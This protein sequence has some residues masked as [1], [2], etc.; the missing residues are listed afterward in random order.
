MLSKAG[1]SATCRMTD[2]SFATVSAGTPLG[3]S[4][5]I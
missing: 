1:S 4:T 3:A 5:P 2:V